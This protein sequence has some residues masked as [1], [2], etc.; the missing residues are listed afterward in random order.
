MFLQKSPWNFTGFYEFH[1][2]SCVKVVTPGM[3]GFAFLREN[4]P[5]K[6]IGDDLSRMLRGRGGYRF[7]TKK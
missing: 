1:N 3:G 4:D 2:I 6:F 5:N 7:F